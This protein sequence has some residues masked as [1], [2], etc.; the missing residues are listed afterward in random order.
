MI[1]GMP[2]VGISGLFYVLLALWIL[3]HATYRSWRGHERVPWRFLAWHGTIVGGILLSLVGEAAL[4]KWGFAEA[5]RFLD[6]THATH[7]AAWF[8]QAS[9]AVAPQFAILPALIL[10]ALLLLL[11]L[12]QMIAQGRFEGASQAPRSAVENRS[13]AVARPVLAVTCPVPP[14][15]W[16]L[17][18]SSGKSTLRQGDATE[19]ARGQAGEE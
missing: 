16:S 13:L 14:R 11:K 18:L 17:T 8:A 2:G 15:S 4:I 9:Q 3:I 12:G 5:Y 7:A 19:R 6:A 10:A 1:A